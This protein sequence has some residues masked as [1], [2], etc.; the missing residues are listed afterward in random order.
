MSFSVWRKL[1][2]IMPNSSVYGSFEDKRVHA[3]QKFNT[4]KKPFLKKKTPFLM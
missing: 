2:F 1:G 3:N 4:L